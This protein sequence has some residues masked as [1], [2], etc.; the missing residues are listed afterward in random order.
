MSSDQISVAVTR[1]LPD[2]V[3]ARLKELFDVKLRDNDEPMTRLE[4]AEIVKSVDVLVP[5][6]TDR[7]DAALLAQAGPR[8]KL[9]ANFGAG[10]DHIDIDTARQRGVL[11][12]N[13]PGVLTDDTADMAMALMLR[14]IRAFSKPPLAYFGFYA[15]PWNVIN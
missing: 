11:V 10:I 15:L 4:L 1:R 9:L 7:I 13:T 3:E 5:T 14:P 12:S 8:L 2:V 6:V